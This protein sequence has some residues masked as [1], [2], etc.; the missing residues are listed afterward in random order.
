MTTGQL[1]KEARKKVGLTQAD[2][3]KKLG[4][5]ASFVA[6]YETDNR[7][8]KPETLQRIAAA[9]RVRVSDLVDPTI[10][11]FGFQEGSEAEE[12]LNHQ[13]DELWKEEGY[14]YSEHECNLINA[15]SQ[16][17]DIGQQEAVKRV[18]ELAEIPRYR[19][20][21]LPKSPLPPQIEP[22]R[23][24]AVLPE[25]QKKPTPVT[26]DGLD[27]MFMRYVQELTPDQQ[28]MILDQMQ[29]MTGQQK[30]PSSVFAQQITGETTP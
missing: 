11:D 26:E 18:E 10:Y 30:E 7:N 17:N 22:D 15:F 28:L 21:A 23:T 20:I 13:I 24:R 9:L 6:Q 5:S 14:T 8:P 4:V 27:E 25:Q 1:I 3:G 16:L 29:R 2:L 19:A 12:F